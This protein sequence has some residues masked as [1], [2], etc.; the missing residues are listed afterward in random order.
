M[1]LFEKRRVLKGDLLSVIFLGIFTLIYFGRF[2][3]KYN[4]N[5]L[6]SPGGDLAHSGF[7]YSELGFSMLKNGDAPLWNPY[8]FC[9]TPLLASLQA[10]FYYPLRWL[11][12]FMEE[13]NALNI[14]FILHFFL[15][16]LFLYA[17]LRYYKLTPLSSALGG[18][19]FSFSAIPLLHLYAGHDSDIWTIIW[20]PLII[21]FLDLTI[22]YCN[23]IYP[24]LGGIFLGLQI[25]ACHIQHVYYT[26]IA[27]VI[28]LL[29]HLRKTTKDYYYSL[30]GRSL[31]FFFTALGISAIQL[32]PSLE[33]LQNSVRI[34]VGSLAWIGQNSLPPENFLTIFFPGFLGD[35]ISSPYLGRWY[36]WE[37]CLYLGIGA[38]V[39][40]CM[41]LYYPRNRK[42]YFAIWIT[43]LGLF[44]AT[45]KYNVLFPYLVRFFPGFSFFRG[46]A[47]FIYLY[48]FG[49]S[50]LTGYGVEY[51]FRLS[52]KKSVVRFLSRWIIVGAIIGI[53]SISFFHSEDISPLWKRILTFSFIEGER[54]DGI[55]PS[56]FTASD[57][58]NAYTTMQENMSLSLFFLGLI[59]TG[60]YV[61]TKKKRLSK[62]ILTLTICM[63]LFIFGQKYIVSFDRKNVEGEETYLKFLKRDKSLFRIGEI[64]PTPLNK[65]IYHRLFSVGGYAG[66]ILSRYNLF[67]N[68]AQ[69]L[70]LDNMGFA[71]FLKSHSYLMNGLNLK[72][73]LSPSFKRVSHPAFKL[74][75]EDGNMSIYENKNFLPR[76]YLVHK[77]VVMKSEADVLKA[78]ASREFNYL[79]QAIIEDK[80]IQEE[81]M[82]V[83]ADG[84]VT[85][86]RYRPNEI[87]VDINSAADSF[88][89]LA[90]VYYPGWNVYIDGKKDKIYQTDY[91]FRGV[92]ISAGNHKVLFRYEPWSYKIGFFI[93]IFTLIFLICILLYKI[94]KNF[95]K[96]L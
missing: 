52:E 71:L 10:V 81:P 76:A 3:L 50:I 33:M 85:I 60:I 38:I 20:I 80:Y 47:K 82:P 59:L 8:V 39:M 32:L 36:L 93:T 67:I 88:L 73:I 86:T 48:G 22:H 9:G 21:L 46:H 4:G 45:G 70:P 30:F 66:N 15:G 17:L 14:S 31:I 95:I 64:I 69:G 49:M 23:Y 72:Y 74:V 91:I 63:D 54:Y 57:F 7:Y 6:S 34:S 65:N 53:S 92:N 18:I 11:S 51:L 90:D 1:T 83:S 29:F 37:N 41:A 94:K 16:S 13:G 79:K 28:Y 12:F 96:E 44:L 75:Y 19:T 25:L 24:L 89:V 68:L 40:A 56:N 43:I 42:I 35:M 61:S 55:L 5:I 27:M 78:M 2:I 58:M 87:W 62:M 26:I 77:V 84:K